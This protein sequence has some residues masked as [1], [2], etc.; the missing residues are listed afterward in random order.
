MRTSV[1]VTI[2]PD[3][4]SAGA[5]QLRS[6]AEQALEKLE[7]ALLGD[8]SDAVQFY[9]IGD[10]QINKMP[11]EKRIALRDKLRHEVASERGYGSFGKVSVAFVR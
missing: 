4:A 1:T 8:M 2:T 3:I 10:Q 5:G 6:W 9:M 11:M 7:A